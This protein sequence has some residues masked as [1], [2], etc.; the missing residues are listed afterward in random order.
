MEFD[1]Q[2]KP[3]KTG[4][5][6]AAPDYF[7]SP[8]RL[9]LATLVAML[10][11][12]FVAMFEAGKPETWERLGFGSTPDVEPVDNAANNR[13]S[14]R[15]IATQDRESRSSESVFASP[16]LDKFWTRHFDQM[17]FSDRTLLFRLLHAI[18]NQEKLEAAESTNAVSL[19]ENLQAAFELLASKNQEVIGFEQRNQFKLLS[20]LLLEYANG[21]T[22][23][24]D[25]GES[26]VELTRLQTLLD[27][28]AFDSID[29][30]SALNRSAE[31]PAWIRAWQQVSSRPLAVD[32]SD[33]SYIQLAGQPAAWRGKWVRVRGDVR[34]IEA[35]ECKEQ[36]P[37]FESYNVLWIKPVDSNRTPYCVYV[38]SLPDKFPKPAKQ[39]QQIN[40]PVVVDGIFFKLRSYLANNGLVETCP[41]IVADT[42]EWNPVAVL[43]PAPPW[44]PPV[45]LLALFFI[46]MPIAATWLAIGVFRSTTGSGIAPGQNRQREIHETLAGLSGDRNIKTDQEKVQELSDSILPN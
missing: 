13:H 9:R 3:D 18:A 27:R 2:P 31:V 39:F 29:D 22:A 33:A 5:R 17:E 28:L 37:D 19:V 11:L 44:S 25:A 7:S 34:G 16:V 46:G 15:Q 38:R 14:D 32:F 36:L 23:L 8:V 4:A 26:R 21:N 20:Q 41:L 10:G 43:T 12:V 30:R 24:A 35:I 45:W 1:I 40:E 6:R 42:I